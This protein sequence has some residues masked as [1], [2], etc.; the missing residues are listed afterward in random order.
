MKIKRLTTEKPHSLF[1]ATV[2]MDNKW[3]K[4][5]NRSFL[6]LAFDE[7]AAIC[8]LTPIMKAIEA[9]NDAEAYATFILD[10]EDKVRKAEGKLLEDKTQR[11]VVKEQE[12]EE[13]QIE[14]HRLGKKRKRSWHKHKDTVR[15]NLGL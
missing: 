12:A 11:K 13:R 15:R 6:I 9:F 10:H 14:T 8:F 1:I 7:K 3:E 2:G 4:Q 5:K